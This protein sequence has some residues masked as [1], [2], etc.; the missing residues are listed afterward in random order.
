M[1]GRLSG[2]KPQEEGGGSEDHEGQRTF[3]SL[4]SPFLPHRPVHSAVLTSALLLPGQPAHEAS[5]RTD[6]AH[7]DSNRKPRRVSVAGSQRAVERGRDWP[8]GCDPDDHW[9]CV[10]EQVYGKSGRPSAASRRV[11][12]SKPG[13]PPLPT[14]G[15]WRAVLTQ[16]LRLCC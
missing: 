3:P 1:P 2:G 15:V 4:S 6:P 7:R 10:S 13:K 14:R 9:S 8:A 11:I 5:R 16:G 12:E